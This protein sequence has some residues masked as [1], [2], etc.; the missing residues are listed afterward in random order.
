MISNQFD[1]NPFA[2]SSRVGEILS[3]AESMDPFEIVRN[4][5]T[6]PHMSKQTEIN[7][8]LE[9]EI[10]IKLIAKTEPGIA[11]P[12]PAGNVISFKKKFLFLRVAKESI[13]ENITA[14]K[15]AIRPK[16]IVFNVRLS[17]SV[18]KPLFN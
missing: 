1:P 10:V 16:L 11:Y 12:I 17:S 7:V 13:K 6:Y 8:N 9:E 3:S 4:L 15:D 14:I 5:I 2:A 18:V